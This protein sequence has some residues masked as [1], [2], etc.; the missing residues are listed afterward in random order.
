MRSDLDDIMAQRELDWI[1]GFGSSSG[2]TDLAY[3]AGGAAVGHVMALKRRGEPPHFVVG[4][5]ER[6]EARRAGLRF[7][8]P[9]DYGAA[10]I[11]KLAVPA[12]ER[13]LRLRL[14]VLERHEVA[15]RVSFVGSG[16]IADSYAT[17]R[18]ILERRP[19]IEF[20]EEPSPSAIERAR[21]TKDAREL[22][23]I[24]AVGEATEA[25]VL[26]VLR[27]LARDRVEGGVLV[28]A[29]GAP[30]KI[31]DVKRWIAVGCLERGL[32]EHGET[33]F[34]PGREA[35]FPHSRGTDTDPVPAGKP[36]VFDIFPGERGGG[37]HFDMTRTI[38]IGEPSERTRACF[39]AVL[40]AFEAGRDACR[41][42]ALAR[43]ADAAASAVLERHGHPTRRRDPSIETGYIH[44]L[45]HGIGL[46]V[47]E[48]PALSARETNE[49]RLEPGMVFTIEPG[50]YYP[51]E[52][53]GIRIEDTLWLDTEGVHT[54]NRLPYE[55]EALW[56]LA[57]GE[58][59]ERGRTR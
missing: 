51:D 19:A 7:A 34:A 39:A 57:R 11:A 12:R 48:Y 44:S 24:R 21:A 5:M 13:A 49:D 32:D 38:W 46:A 40:E 16:A 55:P 18:A 2:S 10:E 17:V 54:C 41:P 29:S 6:E 36:I 4:I 23:R 52:E 8:T 45:G 37:Y 47:H 53:I 1:V 42:G 20:V 59:P 9:N 50:L 22:E 3:L 15:G 14:A 26:E 43:E 31:G 35:G 30:R 27:R 25:V 33:I 28:D 56:A 58:G